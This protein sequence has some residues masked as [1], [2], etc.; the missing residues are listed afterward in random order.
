MS[1][2][3]K[4]VSFPNNVEDDAQLAENNRRL[5]AAE[6][7]IARLQAQREV[8]LSQKSSQD[9]PTSGLKRQKS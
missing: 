7:E 8:Y 9:S 2:D 1:P 6:E 3:R 5:R 4:S